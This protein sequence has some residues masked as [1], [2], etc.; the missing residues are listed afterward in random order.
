MT[1]RSYRLATRKKRQRIPKR[2]PGPRPMIRPASDSKGYH[3]T[4]LTRN[5]VPWYLLSAHEWYP[6]KHPMTTCLVRG[7]GNQRRRALQMD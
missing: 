2:P 1:G 6:F 5:R 7:Q 3:F 4:L